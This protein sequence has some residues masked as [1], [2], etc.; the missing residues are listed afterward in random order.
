MISG[1]LSFDTFKGTGTFV[2]S[3]GP[4]WLDVS[5]GAQEK[6]RAMVAYFGVAQN[7]IV[8]VPRAGKSGDTTVDLA[9]QPQHAKRFRTL[10]SNSAEDESDLLVPFTIVA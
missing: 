10:V 3:W 1:R 9:L 5:M 6:A 8:E 2:N 4:R 7:L